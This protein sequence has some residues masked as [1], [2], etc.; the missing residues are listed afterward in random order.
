M[1]IMIKKD[2]SYYVGKGPLD[3]KSLVKTYADLTKSS[4]WNKTIDGVE[5]CIAYNG[6]LVA[7]WLNK[8]DTSK[9]GIYFLFDSSVTS[10]LGVPDVTKAENWHRIDKNDGND[11]SE[12]ISRLTALE[13]SFEEHAESAPQITKICG[14]TAFGE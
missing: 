11:I 14:G 2:Q 3:S 9:N 12:V 10:A 7:V 4:N 8:T 13:E 6:M 5:T 1:A